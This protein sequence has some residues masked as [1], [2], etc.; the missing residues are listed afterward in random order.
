MPPEQ[1]Q[2]PSLGD[3]LNAY[4]HIKHHI[5]L[6]PETCVSHLSQL[7]PQA[8]THTHTHSPNGMWQ[9]KESGNVR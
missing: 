1:V 9:G 3:V 2:A 5:F 7:G 4:H 6:W 8:H